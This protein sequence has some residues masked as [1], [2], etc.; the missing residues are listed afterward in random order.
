MDDMADS[1]LSKPW[2]PAL[3]LAV[4]LVGLVLLAGGI[5][6]LASDTEGAWILVLWGA[7]LFFGLGFE[8]IRYKPLLKKRPGAGWVRTSERFIDEETAETVTVYVD[9]ATGERA[10]VRE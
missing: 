10:Y 8:R 4:G 2:S 9:P 7:L 1:A 5:A 3:R 6:L